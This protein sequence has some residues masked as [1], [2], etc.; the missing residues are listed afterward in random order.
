MK[1]QWTLILA[2]LFALIVAVFAVINVNPV[3]VDYLFGVAN[4][5]LILVILGSSVMGAIAAG[6]IGIFRLLQ[7]QRKI[8]H[9][10]KENNELQKKLHDHEQNDQLRKQNYELQ[11]ATKPDEKIED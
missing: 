8:K 1:G 9:L 7:Q 3:E 6:S 10:Q 2:L 5:P 11:N 4:W